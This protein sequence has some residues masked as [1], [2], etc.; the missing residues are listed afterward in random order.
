MTR[1]ADRPSNTTTAG[2]LPN[3]QD[4]Q[5][6]KRNGE[7]LLTHWI[8]ADTTLRLCIRHSGALDP[9]EFCCEIADTNTDHE[10]RLLAALSWH[11]DDD[12]N[13]YEWP[14]E[15]RDD[16]MRLA[17]VWSAC[18]KLAEWGL[19]LG[20]TAVAPNHIEAVAEALCLEETGGPAPAIGFVSGQEARYA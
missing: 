15:W 2:T 6:D 20:D 19:A 16:F 13:L 17:R 12:P 3:C 10:F 18:L 7:W 5:I 8:N 1:N 4:V 14:L 9:D 11:R